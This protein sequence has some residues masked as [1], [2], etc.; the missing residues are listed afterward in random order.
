VR[1]GLAAFELADDLGSGLIEVV[2]DRGREMEQDTAMTHVGRILPSNNQWPPSTAIT[3]PVPNSA[4]TRRSHSPLTG[5]PKRTVVKSPHH[6]IQRLSRA[7]THAPQPLPTQPT[8]KARQPT[9]QS[10]THNHPG[11]R[12]GQEPPTCTNDTPRK[13]LALQY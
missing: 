6:I 1:V 4:E 13:N 2:D 8:T 10:P 12:A 11:Q 7:G 9:R 3:Q 5:N